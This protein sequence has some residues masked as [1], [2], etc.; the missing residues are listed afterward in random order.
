MGGDLDFLGCSNERVD[1]ESQKMWRGSWRE[2]LPCR[3]AA[4]DNPWLMVVLETQNRVLLLSIPAGSA[5]HE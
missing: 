4:S 3:C 5:Y 1:P 2:L